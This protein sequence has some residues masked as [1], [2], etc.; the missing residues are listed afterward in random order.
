MSASS[1]EVIRGIDQLADLEPEW[2]TLWT[3]ISQAT[4]FQSP[5]WILPWWKV[6]GPGEFYSVAAYHNGKLTGLAPMWLEHAKTVRLLPIGIGLSDYC[7]ALLDPDYPDAGAV[8]SDG[9]RSIEK[10]DVCEFPELIAGACAGDLPPPQ[11]CTF[12]IGLASVAPV[13]NIPD[14]ARE[15]SQVI[16]TVQNRHVRRAFAAANRRGRVEFSTACAGGEQD[17]LAEL[18]RLHTAR[19][20]NRGDRG[21]FG[22]PRVAQFHSSALPK[23]VEAE[24]LRMYRMSINGRA[25]ALYYGF[26]DHCRSYAYLQGYDPE[27]AEC[28]PGSLIVAHAV[29]EALR[30]GTGEFHFLRGDEA[31]KFAW[32]A[33]R[34]CNRTIRFLRETA[35]G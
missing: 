28:S 9:F 32:G 15:L 26:F 19:W 16:P 24:L 27:Y 3:R 4:V 31:Y 13:L 17:F 25:V 34:R 12:E 21:V 20:S 22:D 30:E 18:I 5:A 8:L 14:Q 1:F 6:F 35:N 23:L 7:D 11:A 29:R 10:W 2:W 33:M